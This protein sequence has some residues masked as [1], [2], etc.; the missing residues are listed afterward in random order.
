MKLHK[1]KVEI[2]W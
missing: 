2:S 1:M